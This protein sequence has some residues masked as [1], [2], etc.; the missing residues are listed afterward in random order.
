MPVFSGYPCTGYGRCYW[1]S[2][3]GSWVFP[4]KKAYLQEQASM[5]DYNRLMREQLEGMLQEDIRHAVFGDIFLEDLRLYR[6]A[7]LAKIG[8]Q[9][10][11]PI[12]KQDSRHL[13]QEIIAA[14][15]KAI[16]VCANARYLDASFAG[17]IIDEQ[18]LADLPSNVDPCGENGEFHT[19]VYDGPLFKAPVAFTPGDTVER[20]YA[21][22][23]VSDSS[24]GAGGSSSGV[25]N[26]SSRADDARGG[27]KPVNWDNHFY[28]KELLPLV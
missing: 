21:P 11:F 9:G 25:D 7:Q 17:R 19:F 1:M 20:S 10:V 3:H 27:Q 12:W 4:L 14:G 16:V 23:S 13:L 28:F 5:E 15:F 2:R 22:A 24:S 8:M 26:A 6:E 18:F